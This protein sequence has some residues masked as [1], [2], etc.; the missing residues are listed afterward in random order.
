[1]PDYTVIGSGLW[2]ATIARTLADAG[3]TV[4]VV[5]RK[6]HIGGMVYSVDMDGI[7]VHRY[8]AHIFHTNN[9]M[10]WDYVN[11]FGEWRQY[12]HRVKSLVGGRAYSFPVNLMT[13]QQ[14]SELWPN[15]NGDMTRKIHKLFYEGYTWKMW[16]REVPEGVTK[17]VPVRNNWDDRYFSDRY[18]GVPE[19]GWTSIIDKMLD[20]IE[21]I[22]EV[23][24][25]NDIDYWRRKSKRIFYSGALDELFGY[26]SGSL[27]YR[28]IS[29]KDQIVTG[30]YQG[31]A[32][33][34]H[35]SF[36][37]PYI[38]TTEH[39]HLGWYTNPKTVVSWEYAE[40]YNGTNEPLYPVNTPTN[41]AVAEIY[42]RKVSELPWLRVG[43]R[44]GS[45]QYLN[46]DQVISQAMAIAGKELQ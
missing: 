16:G 18:Q 39:K 26:E 29:W 44:L 9:R 11:R 27:G 42:R 19:Y 15:L 40:P 21:V 34:N 1:M 4:T 32:T 25:L 43:G 17:R 37:M 38:R 28:S 8:G 6:P 14:I 45:Y 5:E 35:P 10:I 13:V 30:D 2:G 31:T 33:I 12:E 41:Q 22:T 23:D 36:D 24:A 3:K 20:R 46:M 7:I